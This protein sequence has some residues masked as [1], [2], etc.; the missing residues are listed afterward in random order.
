M[1][2]ENVRLLDVYTSGFREMETH[3]KKLP[4]PQGINFCFAMSDHSVVE[5]V[6]CLYYVKWVPKWHGISHV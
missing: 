5:L 4:W 1:G 2:R 6:Y 3:A